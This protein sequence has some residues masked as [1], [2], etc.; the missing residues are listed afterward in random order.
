MS[1]KW[2]IPS[3]MVS[4]NY[5]G[6]PVDEGF[7]RSLTLDQP[8]S[9]L[10][11]FPVLFSGTYTYL[12]TVG[13][14]GKVQNANGYDI[15]FYSD[16]A[17]TTLLDFERVFWDGATGV[18]E[19]WVRVPTLTSASALVIYLAYGNTSISSDQQDAAGTWNTNYKGVWHF[20]DGTTLGLNDSTGVN[21]GTNNNATATTGQIDGGIAL[22]GSSQYVNIGT[23]SSLAPLTDVSVEVWVNPTD[24]T[25]YNS[26]LAR[27]NSNIPSPFEARLD[28]TTGLMR[29]LAKGNGTTGWNEQVSNTAIANST[30]THIMFVYDNTNNLSI[31]YINGS[32]D[33]SATPVDTGTPNGV[34]N[35]NIT[36]IATREDFATMFKG[37]M[38]ELRLSNT[39]RTADWVAASFSNQNDP[40]NFYIIGSETPA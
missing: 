28:Q 22:S 2:S 11:N 37:S 3:L 34:D 7:Y 10:S 36:Y 6:V 33:R 17:L 19:F 16:A 35:G 21:N 23:N 40:A 14:G 5:G 1:L 18:V 9:D 12:K 8:A 24:R 4:G 31:F 15:T 26:V 13:N 30:W 39:V 25:Q 32:L 27:C 38:D 29:L 20:P